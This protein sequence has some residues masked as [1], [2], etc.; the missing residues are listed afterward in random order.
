M[1]YWVQHGYGKGDKI[2]D[3]VRSGLISGGVILSPADEE[4]GALTATA[5][6]LSDQG[7]RCLV[8]PQFYV[9]SIQGGTARCH[10]S[11]SIEFG[12]LTWFL[13]PREIESHVEAILRLNTQ[14]GLSEHI[15]P[16][17]YLAAFNDVW[18][19]IALQYSRAFL[20]A[21]EGS[22]FIS[23]VAEDVAFADWQATTDWLDA[24]TTLDAHG[25]YLIVSHAGR[26]YPFAWEPDRLANVLRVIYA[27][28]E[29]NEY[30]V[31]W[32]YADLAG[33][34]GVA[35]GADGAATGWF[36]SLRM[37]TP[38]KWLPSTG[39][40]QA[41]PR[42]LALP[43]LSPLEATSEAASAARSSLGDEIFRAADLRRHFASPNAVW[44]L[45]DAWAQHMAALSTAL[46]DVARQGGISD[47]T[48]FLR[49]WI[50]DAL[51]LLARLGEVGAAVGP[52][53]ATRLEAMD[54]AL[55]LFSTAEGL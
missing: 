49:G 32:G 12:E 18:A 19:P 31:V 47:S 5:R 39:G 24:V 35:A 28:S 11:N 23:L 29:V 2:A 15:A 9:H 10:E 34:A 26:T 25:I 38:Q 43:L 6:S 17:P 16:S 51:D 21:S 1:T 33:L 7:V 3:M 13:S 4:R 42:V 52:S 48:R 36:H 54:R 14:L 50:T 27:L 30:E 41:T 37:W 45:T 40:R 53:H 46:G 44:G 8:D 20:E 55:E 22:S